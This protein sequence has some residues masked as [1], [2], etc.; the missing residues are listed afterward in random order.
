MA[1]SDDPTTYKIEPGAELAGT[2]TVADHQSKKV[3]LR[4]ER[5]DEVKVTRFVRGGSKW[6]TEYTVVQRTSTYFGP[7]LLLHTEFNGRDRN[8]RLTCPGP[9]SH[10]ILWAYLSN[11]DG[12]Q[13][14]CQPIAEVEAMIAGTE[15]YRLC[16]ICGQPVRGLWHERYQA[17]GIDH[18]ADAFHDTE[19]TP[20]EDGEAA[21]GLGDVGRSGGGQP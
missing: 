20:G 1:S 12:Y 15:R 21:L 4:A 2:E 10:L 18:D 19:L 16:D 14:T 6:P 3:M 5:R 17:F 8:F 9:H 7:V 11:L 13:H